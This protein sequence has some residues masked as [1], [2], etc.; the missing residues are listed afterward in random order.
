[1]TA[2]LVARHAQGW[3]RIVPLPPGKTVAVGRDKTN[4]LVVDDELCSRQHAEILADEDGW[5]LRDLGSSNGT[6]VNGQLIDEVRL[7]PSDVIAVGSSRFVFVEDLDHLLEPEPAGGAPSETVEV[8]LR[9]SDTRF[10]S[11]TATDDATRTR[12]EADSVRLYKMTLDLAKLRDPEALFAKVMDVVLEATPADTGAI[13]TAD[14]Q[15]R[16]GTS[17]FRGP[18]TYQGVSSAITDTVLQ[19]L[20]A[21]LTRDVQADR[22]LSKRKSIGWLGATSAICAPVLVEDKVLG[23]IHLYTTAP[24]GELSRDD[25]EF[26]MGVANQLGIA[27]DS[28]RFR[29]GLESQNR[30]LRESLRLQSELNGS[31]PAMMRIKEAIARVAQVNATVL[32]RGESGSGKELAARALHYC[33]RRAQGPFVCL[34]CAAISETLLESELFGHEKGAFTGATDRKIGK[35]EAADGGTIF[36][37]EIGDMKVGTQAKLLRV[38]EGHPYERVGGREPIHVEVRVVAATNRPLEQAV[39]DDAFREDLYFRLQ[40]VEI[41]MPPLREH[42]DDIPELAEHFL[43]RFREETARPVRGF[44]P[45]ALEKLVAHDWPGNVRELKNSIERA[46]ALGTGDYV[47]ADDILLSPL[48]RSMSSDRGG[49]PPAYR[50]ISVEQ[51]EKEHI[52][53]TLDHTNWRKAEAATILGIERSTLNRKIVRYC[54]QPPK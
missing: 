32:I 4:A 36:L 53:A 15:G 29:E 37:D 42:K 26:V 54:L 34:N 49:A 40:V 10:L 47:G 43:E 13:L 48:A 24:P 12:A 33:S 31:S 18:G 25:L 2:Y 17:C 30:Q 5:H 11:P 21:V 46:V 50:P 19:S 45:S 3:G 39:R 1:M 44:T 20:E 6:R 8:R 22:K 52:A 51:M 7:H 27:M 14:E 23:L 35:F 38:L 9:Q 28:I 41:V 16:L